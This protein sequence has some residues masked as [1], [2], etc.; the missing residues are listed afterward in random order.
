[1]LQ[2][3]NCRDPQ[4]W[5]IL[6]QDP[7]HEVSCYRDKDA[8]C[9]NSGSHS[10]GSS[11]SLSGWGIL[12]SLRWRRNTLTTL[13]FHGGTCPKADDGVKNAKMCVRRSGQSRHYADLF[14]TIWAKPPIPSRMKAWR[15]SSLW[16][17]LD[18]VLLKLFQTRTDRHRGCYCKGNFYMNPAFCEHGVPN[19]LF[20]LQ[21]QWWLC[22]G[23][24]CNLLWDLPFP[25]R[26][27]K[28]FSQRTPSHGVLAFYF[29]LDPFI[30]KKISP[31]TV[32]GPFPP[33][34]FIDSPFCP[35]AI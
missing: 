31:V 15:F 27:R 28:A 3:Q 34:H 1:M 18:K 21:W 14:Q 26:E 9:R 32:A 19:S 10:P 4:L 35:F 16:H 8:S 33:Q 29:H 11:C 30:D 23:R 6:V 22:W 12:A 20:R 5:W 24:L 25:K 2:N 17:F 13:N 7:E